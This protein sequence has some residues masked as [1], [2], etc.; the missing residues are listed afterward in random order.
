MLAVHVVLL[1]AV[2]TIVLESPMLAQPFVSGALQSSIIE[3]LGGTTTM[4]PGGAEYRLPLV[5]AL[6]VS[7]VWTLI[8]AGGIIARNPRDQRLQQFQWIPIGTTPLIAWSILW[9]FISGSN[10]LDSIQTLYSFLD[11]VVALT[12]AIWLFP[13]MRCEIASPRSGYLILGGAILLLT[14]VQTAMNW[15]LWFNLRLPHGDSAM[16]EEHLWNFTHGKGFRSY[17]DQGLFLGEHIQVVHLLLVPLHW[18]WPSQMMMEL[19]ESLALAST[20]VPVYRICLRHSQHRST[21]LLLGLATLAYVPLHYLDI[22]I[23]LKTF[24]PISFGIPAVVWGIDFMERRRWCGMSLWFLLALSSKEDFAIILAPIGLLLAVMPSIIPSINEDETDS[25]ATNQIRIVGLLLCVLSTA[26]LLFVVKFAIPWFR[27]GET[28]H[29]ARYFSAFGETPTEIV[30][31]MLTRPQLVVS[32]LITRNSIRYALLMLLPLGIFMKSGACLRLLTGVPLFVLLCLNELAQQP[33]GPFHHFHAPLI[34][35]VLWAYAAGIRP[36]IHGGA[37][38][39]SCAV[40]TLVFFS[41][42]PWSIKFWDSGSGLYWQRLYSQD[43]RAEEFFRILPEISLDQRIASTDY[44]HAHLTHAQRSYDYSNYPRR[45]S[46]YEPKVPDDTNL[47]VLDLQ[48]LAKLDEDFA[49]TGVVRELRESPDRW[50]VASELS[51]K[52]FLILKR[53]SQAF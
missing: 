51:S 43:E 50:D 7:L 36:A 18:L 15:G 29:Y 46:D 2:L 53:K 19:C 40:A 45:V 8:L 6:G 30:W 27:D 23:D 14:A 38:A 47:I 1:M 42:G 17:L 32:Q 48:H 34:P 26:Y 11:L 52:Y 35:I 9:L 28:V 16:Y 13:M 20:A 22:A 10:N 31:S 24:R 25:K 5:S 21:A 33:P 12:L 44:V 4:T 37:W 3:S 39:M 49:R 41:F